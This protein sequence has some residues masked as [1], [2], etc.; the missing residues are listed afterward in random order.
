MSVVSIE[1]HIAGLGA[2]AAHKSVSELRLDDVAQL[3]VPAIEGKI[4]L[5]RRRTDVDRGFEIG[6]VERIV[7]EVG[8][9]AIGASQIGYLAA[10]IEG[11]AHGN[12]R[13]HAPAAADDGQREVRVNVDT[14][15]VARVEAGLRA[16]QMA[17]RRAQSPVE[18]RVSQRPIERI[19]A[20]AGQMED[21][22]LVARSG[23]GK[24]LQAFQVC[25]RN[26]S[27]V[28][29]REGRGCCAPQS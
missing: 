7:A 6:A 18:Q 3:A 21:S 22:G 26:E 1:Q 28:F 14:A 13:D 24:G 4:P 27:V 25:G 8:S 23:A 17:D 16:A 10:G 19:E 11:V 20:Q 12:L 2:D 15:D 9:A 29:M 5:Q